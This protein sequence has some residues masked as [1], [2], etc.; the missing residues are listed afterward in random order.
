MVYKIEN[1]RDAEQVLE[2]FNYFHDGF[3]QRVELVSHDRFEQEGPAYTD[4]AHVC[5]GT[6]DVS[7]DIAHYNYG[8]GEQPCQRL[9]ACRFENVRDFALD[10]RGHQ[11]HDWPITR[12]DISEVTRAKGFT[13]GEAEPAL[14][15]RLMRPLLVDGTRWER[16][17]HTLFTFSRATL[18]EGLNQE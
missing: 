5:T 2:H 8:Q 6:F 3:I 14:E 1:A 13:P 12:I 18:E 10:L 16:Q 11:G 9:V 4:R 15:L 17:E 7:L